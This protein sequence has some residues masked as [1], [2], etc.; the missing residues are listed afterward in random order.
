MTRGLLGWRWQLLFL[1]CRFHSL[2]T[3]TICFELVIS[4]LPTIHIFSVIL[5]RLSD[6]WP[7]MGFLDLLTIACCFC[8]VI[9]EDGVMWST[10]MSYQLRGYL[11]PCNLYS[12]N[13]VKLKEFLKQMAT[14]Y[15]IVSDGLTVLMLLLIIMKWK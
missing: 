14:V 6:I 13:K 9:S 4:W 15:W 8:A 3:V 12:V 10:L 7:R 5:S 1:C 11:L 2:L